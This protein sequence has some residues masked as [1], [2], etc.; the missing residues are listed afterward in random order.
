MG[1]VLYI[2][3]FSTTLHPVDILFVVQSLVGT[4]WLC[5]NSYW[6]WPSRKFVSFPIN[7]TVMFHSYVIV[8]RRVLANDLGHF[9]EVCLWKKTIPMMIMMLQLCR[10]N[11]RDSLMKDVFR[12]PFFPLQKKHP[13]MS[14]IL[15]TMK[16]AA[17]KLPSVVAKSPWRCI[18][19]PTGCCRYMLREM[20][21][22]LN[23]HVWCTSLCFL[24][25]NS[26]RPCFWSN[27]SC[28]LPLSKKHCLSIGMYQHFYPE[29]H[30]NPRKFKSYPL[31]NV[32]KTMENHNAIHGKT[33]Y[34]DCDFFKFA[35]C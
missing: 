2:V 16:G 27:P 32:Y 4:L 11:W 33:H 1:M 21:A 13:C 25:Q 30:K 10:V 5:Q 22:P 28:F 18:P 19:C 7:S 29:V 8:Y 24:L 6:T 9:W 35:N 31:V 23:P 34:F 14:F 12:P 3:F 17:Q 15:K 20:V 26:S